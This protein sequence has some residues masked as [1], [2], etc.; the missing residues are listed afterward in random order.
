MQQQLPTLGR[1]RHLQ[2]ITQATPTL[3][4][5]A[6]KV[7]DRLQFFSLG[8][9]GLDLP[10]DPS[11][12]CLQPFGRAYEDW[13]KKLLELPNG[14]PSHDTFARVFG[15]IDPACMHACFARWLTFLV[16]SLDV[17]GSAASTKT[18]AIDGKTL[19][20]SNT[21]K[22]TTGQPP[23]HLVSAWA[24]ESGL[25]LG[26]VATDE[27]S[28][29]ITAIPEL[30][31]MLDLPGETVTIDAMGCQRDIA[32]KLHENKAD[33][34]LALKENHKTLHTQAVL[35]MAEADRSGGGGDASITYQTHRTDER[36]HGREET[37][38]YTTARLDNQTT[39]RISDVVRQD[40]PGLVGVGRV[41]S[42]RTVKGKTTTQHRYYLLTD[43]D[44]KRFA[45]AVRGH[46][47]IENQLHW[48]LDVTM[49]EDANRTS[50]DHGPENLAILR[51]LALNLLRM[52]R[53]QTKKTMKKMRNRIAYGVSYLEELFNAVFLMR[54]PWAIAISRIVNCFVLFP[55][56]LI[57]RR[58]P[59]R[60]A[61]ADRDEFAVARQSGGDL[62]CDRPRDAL[63]GGVDLQAAAAIGE[64]VALIQVVVLPGGDC[65]VDQGLGD[66]EIA[67]GFDGV[68]FVCGDGDRD[69]PV[70]AVQG[71]E[72][73][74]GQADGVGGGECGLDND[75]VH[76][77]HW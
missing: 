9:Q 57:H 77:W 59:R 38:L 42:T 67:D 14:I 23:L 61:D 54:W 25:V 73:P 5:A 2:Q 28:S 39:H 69:G 49:G 47:G 50:K 8:L 20:S 11:A 46:W 70:V 21:A 66:V 7:T 24:H 32:Q 4:E 44:V 33:Y 56:G 48:V 62:F 58:T 45:K 6:L 75:L 37:R 27:K 64:G 43:P 10:L 30:L 52:A 17:D 13:F 71:L 55:G 1:S 51:R 29:E 53:E 76:R 15:L 31:D 18:I 72:R 40:W 68:E 16:Q 34:A 41:V 12:V 74:V 35:L 36:G 19:R 22:G 65:R 63:G 60:F 26:Q 3:N